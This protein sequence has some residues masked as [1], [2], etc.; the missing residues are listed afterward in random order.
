M[1]TRGL[2]ITF[3][4][5]EGAGKSSQ[6]Q[7]LAQRM[8]QSGW[9]THTTREPGGTPLAEKIRQ[10]LVSG[11]PTAMNGTTELLLME[12]ARSD[13]V[14][15][16]RQ[17]MEAGVHVLCDRFGDSSLAYQGYGRGM[18]VDW[19][20]QLNHQ[21]TGGLQPDLTFLLDVDEALGLGRSKGSHKGEDRFEQEK[22]EFHQRVR[23]GFLNLA[24]AS[25]ER[26]R[27]VDGS[28]SLEAI[29]QK[30]WQEVEDAIRRL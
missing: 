11:S 24:A 16:I 1:A 29:S 13:H 5:G 25:P 9:T 10:L 7:L 6:V 8:G 4:G 26:F 27:V 18:D 20:R 28:Q 14:N 12:A 19:I 3:E 22:R 23:Q 15:L 21:A 2:F 30:I 17:Y